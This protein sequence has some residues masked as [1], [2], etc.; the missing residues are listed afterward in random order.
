MIYDVEPEQLLFAMRDIQVD[1]EPAWW[2]RLL[3]VLT[4]IAVFIVEH[5]AAMKSLAT[6]DRIGGS[7]G[8]GRAVR[9]Q[10]YAI[11][12][13]PYLVTIRLDR[14]QCHV[15]GIFI[16]ISFKPP[17]IGPWPP[18]R[19]ELTS[20]TSINIDD[21]LWRRPMLVTYRAHLPFDAHPADPFLRVRWTFRRLDRNEVVSSAD[22][23]YASN[24]TFVVDYSASDLLL[25]PSFSVETRV[26]RQTLGFPTELSSSLETI[27]VSDRLDRSHPYVHWNHKVMVPI[28]VVGPNDERTLLRQDLIQRRSKIHRTHVPGR[29]RMA[30]CFAAELSGAAKSES[31]HVDYLDALPFPVPD[32]VARR[33]EVC[34]YCFFGGPSKSIPLPLP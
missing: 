22:G 12:G 34:D 33:G 2:A 29:C 3:E 11:A 24:A 30:S 7:G 32:L 21:L 6:Y 13:T 9:N 10:T 26:Y 31:Q 28:V 8:G 19:E 25:S 15:D 4:G 27:R 18:T 1:T 5:L 20:T 14:F 23:P 16:G 17:G